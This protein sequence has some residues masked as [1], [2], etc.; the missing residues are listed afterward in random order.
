MIADL[1]PRRKAEVPVFFRETATSAHV[2]GHVFQIPDRGSGKAL[3]GVVAMS[4]ESGKRTDESVFWATKWTKT[5]T[6]T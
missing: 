3:F 5:S 4:L 1:G 2:N 6:L